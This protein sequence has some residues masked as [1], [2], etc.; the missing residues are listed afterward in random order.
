MS[1]RNTPTLSQV[2]DVLFTEVDEQATALARLEHHFHNR[3]LVDA[4]NVITVGT[5]AEQLRLRITPEECSVVLD[6]IAEKQLVTITID[7]AEDGVCLLHTGL[8]YCESRTLMEQADEE[9]PLR[10]SCLI[11]GCSLRCPGCRSLPRRR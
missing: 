3:L 2:V 1:T 8:I 11:G 4:G 10:N 9:W 7:V 5:Y 6:Y